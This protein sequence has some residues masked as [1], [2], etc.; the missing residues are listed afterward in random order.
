M[1]EGGYGSTFEISFWADLARLL[2]G[3]KNSP[4]NVCGL[5]Q[6]LKKTGSNSVKI[7]SR[8]WCFSQIIITSIEYYIDF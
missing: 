2:A 5:L 6:Y 8:H 7:F 3:I 1:G 4:K